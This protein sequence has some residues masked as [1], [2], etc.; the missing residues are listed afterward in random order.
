MPHQGLQRLT[1]H[2]DGVERRERSSFVMK[3]VAMASWGA[4]VRL[5]IIARKMNA[6][7]ILDFGEFGVESSTVVFPREYVRVETP[8][9]A[10]MFD[11]KRV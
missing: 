4:V 6:R 10:N 3:A 8:Q 1:G 11:N 2:I 9:S 7:L 5:R